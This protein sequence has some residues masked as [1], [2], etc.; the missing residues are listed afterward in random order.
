MNI[1]MD[2]VPGAYVR[3]IQQGMYSHAGIPDILAC[4]N[5]KFVAI[6]VKTATGKPTMLQKRELN[7]IREAGGVALICYGEADIRRVVDDALRVLRP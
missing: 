6:E 1:L 3:K 7:F 5:S 4:I 2:E